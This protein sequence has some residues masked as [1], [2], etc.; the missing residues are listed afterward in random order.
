M[1]DENPDA[2]AAELECRESGPAAAWMAGTGLSIVFGVHACLLAAAA[3]AI[4]ALTP[5]GFVPARALPWAA[6]ALWVISVGVGAFWACCGRSGRLWPVGLGVGLDGFLIALGVHFC[7][8]ELPSSV[9]GGILLATLSAAG[10]VGALMGGRAQARERPA[11]AVG[12]WLVSDA[13][14]VLG[15]VAALCTAIAV[16]FPG[17]FENLT[18][19]EARLLA[20]L[21][22]LPALGAL[23]AL[24]GIGGIR[25][26]L[27]RSATGLAVVVLLIA[28][29]AALTARVLA[30][31][32]AD[33]LIDRA[34]AEFGRTHAVAG[35]RA[36]GAL[37]DAAR[38]APLCQ[39]GG[40]LRVP[41]SLRQGWPCGPSRELTEALAE[42]RAELQ[43]ARA[44]LARLD[45]S[46]PIALD[47]EAATTVRPRLLSLTAVLCAAALVPDA[48]ASEALA[49]LDDA[50]S[51]A[52][53]ELPNR[54]LM[55]DF[56]ADEEIVLA[57]FER[58]LSARALD[59]ATARDALELLAGWE[60][61]RERA[62]SFWAALARVHAATSAVGA[63][64]KRSAESVPLYLVSLAV[65]PAA[66]VRA[67]D[68][69]IERFCADLDGMPAARLHAQ[70][71][72]SAYL[73]RVMDNAL[74]QIAGR[75]TGRRVQ[76][77][78]DVWRLQ[79]ESE[80]VGPVADAV[81]AHRANAARLRL[82]AAGLT[83]RLHEHTT[84]QPSDGI[85][86]LEEQSP[87][88]LRD[89]FSPDLLQRVA[90]GGEVVFFSAGP[91][92][93]PG[94]G[95]GPFSTRWPARPGAE[96]DDIA[97]PLR[98]IPAITGEG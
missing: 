73:D 29:G 37:A 51:L 35:R 84:G 90:E 62:A 79:A 17:E 33:S 22:A 7:A 98:R 38:K 46:V 43:E 15:A 56:A 48:P 28:L 80:A 86:T 58:L 88:P 25:R 75:L 60:D 6:G 30:N 26:C 61:R 63:H 45:G 77:R 72:R 85:G 39:M 42:G 47:A 11:D 13:L 95:S 10:L 97:L 70:Y 65:P 81:T 34:I 59:A 16:G 54:S 49:L 68:D 4:L 20:V 8:V 78:S 5:L 27:L 23:L 21:S 12:R 92:G 52:L 83:A 3:V 40:G 2:A 82:L 18:R 93:R 55:P 87:V 1:P 94:G 19:E 24:R 50:H 76:N 53:S 9:V 36:V 32:A 64:R 96:G 69:V 71:G 91:D 31:R 74:D 41:L 67:V 57:A 66:I 44:A 14:L 89:P